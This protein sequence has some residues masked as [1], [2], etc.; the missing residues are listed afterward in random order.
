MQDIKVLQNKILEIALYFDEFCRQN[1][2]E[3]YLMG[4]SALGAVRHQ[5]FIPWDDDFDVFMTYE[6]YQKFLRCARE[7]LDTNRFYLQEENTKEWP[8]FYTKLRMNNTLFLEPDTKD[9]KMH[10]GIFIDIFCLYNISDSNFIAGIQFLA[11]KML[12]AKSLSQRGYA[13]ASFGK[14]ILM[15]IA[16]VFVS[17]KLMI[18]IVKSQMKKQ[19]NRVGQLFGKAKFKRAIF[20]RYYLGKPR[21]V[22][23]ENHYL[24]VPE[25]VEDYLTHVFG[26][27]MKLPSQ[28]EIEKSIHSQQ[29]SIDV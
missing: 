4:G 12:A 19:T 8:L 16:R 3:Y 23:F 1:D 6:N 7:K 2:I 15:A 24:P 11:A 28:E 25:Y 9:R 26:D 27:Y 10:K 17:K 5:G 20:P 21:Y 29:W 18:K 14:K 13:S 22:L